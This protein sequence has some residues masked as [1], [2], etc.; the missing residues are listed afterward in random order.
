MPW[1]KLSFLAFATPPASVSAFSRAVISRV[2]PDDFWGLNEVRQHNKQL[3]MR[4]L[5]QFINLRKF[6]SLSLHEI[7]QGFKVRALPARRSYPR[8]AKEE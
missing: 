8:S 2:I 4:K 1:Q 3:M 7:L 5:D 6:E